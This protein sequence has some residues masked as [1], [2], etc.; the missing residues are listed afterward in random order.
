[1]GNHIYTAGVGDNV[2]VVYL[3]MVIIAM[4]ET[5]LPRRTREK[6]RFREENNQREREREKKK[7]QRS[8]RV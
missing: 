7:K 6:Q 4:E 5:R 2:E 1:V 3:E 8:S